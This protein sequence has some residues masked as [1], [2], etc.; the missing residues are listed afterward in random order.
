MFRNVLLLKNR[1]F[2][3]TVQ[4]NNVLRNVEKKWQQQWQ[5]STPYQ[6]V[7]SSN[8]KDKF[9]SLSMF[10]YPSGSLHMGHVRVYT[11]SDVLVCAVLVD[12]FAISRLF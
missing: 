12:L 4:S 1:R 3:S 11:L 8:K 7:T 9:Y 10:P 6:N 5:K 2:M